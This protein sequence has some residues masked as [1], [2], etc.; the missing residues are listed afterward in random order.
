MV[1]EA[2]GEE[3]IRLGYPV[4]ADVRDLRFPFVS[5]AASGDMVRQ[6]PDDVRAFMRAFVEA[7]HYFKTERAESERILERWMKTDNAKLIDD[8]WDVYAHRYLEAKPYPT[9]RGAEAML[10]FAAQNNPRA[11]GA[12]RRRSSIRGSWKSWTAAASSTA[13]GTSRSSAGP[14]SL[15]RRP[16]ALADHQM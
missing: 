5:V 6:H 8:T 12:I 2:F 3:A 14:P 11:A 7:I 10:E 1:D 16:R 4:L 13:S 9:I 15:R